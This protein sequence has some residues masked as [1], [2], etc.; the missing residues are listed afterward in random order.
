MLVIMTSLLVVLV[1]RSYQ[2]PEPSSQNI[3]SF[4]A[5]MGA[6]HR[7]PS[8]V[9][10][11]MKT[12]MIFESLTAFPADCEGKKLLAECDSAAAESVKAEILKMENSSQS[13]RQV[14]DQIVA[15]YGEKALTEQSRQIRQMRMKSSK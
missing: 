11:P 8:R 7:V 9:L 4:P 14:F 15:K 3:Q 5:S 6:A 10:E 1:V 12:S 2:T 13:P